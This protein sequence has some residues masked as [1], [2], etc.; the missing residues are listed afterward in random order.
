[1]DDLLF[2]WCLLARAYM[3]AD[4]TSLI[5]PIYVMVYSLEQLGVVFLPSLNHSANI[6]L[7]GLHSERRPSCCNVN[8]ARGRH[9]SCGP[10]GNEQ[11]CV[12]PST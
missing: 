9:R 4:D 8:T 2:T 3:P 5:I 10:V 12:I 7:T 11:A 6:S 1:M